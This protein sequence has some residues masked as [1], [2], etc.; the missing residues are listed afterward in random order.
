MTLKIILTVG[1]SIGKTIKSMLTI[2]DIKY[3]DTIE[4]WKRIE[5]VDQHIE[6][7]R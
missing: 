3:E 5:H 6:K 4:Y 1:H 7:R 2:P